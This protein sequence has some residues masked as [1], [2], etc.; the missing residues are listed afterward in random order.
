MRRIW[1][2][3]GYP[4]GIRSVPDDTADSIR[5]SDRLASRTM[6]GQRIEMLISP[7]SHSVGMLISSVISPES[8]IETT[9]SGP[10][11]A[12]LTRETHDH[13]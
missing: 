6:R 9:G 8:V 2:Y 3:D 13:F 12:L 5:T 7:R 10:R 4:L 11:G 1:I